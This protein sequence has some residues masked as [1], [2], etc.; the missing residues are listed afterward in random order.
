M[1]TKTKTYKDKN[2]DLSA[3]TGS[4]SFQEPSPYHRLCRWSLILFQKKAKAFKDTDRYHN[5][6]I[7]LQRRHPTWLESLPSPQKSQRNRNVYL[8]N[9]IA[10][11]VFRIFRISAYFFL[12]KTKTLG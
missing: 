4:G 3:T 9:G 8:T 1:D 12:D 6:S 11:A 2:L 7:G 5:Q 10:F